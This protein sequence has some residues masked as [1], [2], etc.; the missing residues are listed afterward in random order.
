MSAMN[1]RRQ[2]IKEAGHKGDRNAS[3]KELLKLKVKPAV[4]RVTVNGRDT[5]VLTCGDGV[6]TYSF[7]PDGSLREYNS[8]R[9]M[10]AH[11]VSE[12]CRREGSFSYSIHIVDPAT[13]AAVGDEIKL[14]M[15]ETEQ[16]RTFCIRY[17]PSSRSF[18]SDTTQPGNGESV[19]C[20]DDDME[21]K[22]LTDENRNDYQPYRRRSF[23]F[24][25][26][27]KELKTRIAPSPTQPGMQQF[28][29]KED[30]DAPS[31]GSPDDKEA[32]KKKKRRKALSWAAVGAGVGGLLLMPP[33]QRLILKMIT[34]GG[35][36]HR[37]LSEEDKEAIKEDVRRRT[38]G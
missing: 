11:E 8:N 29:E 5:D 16:P 25:K 22:M 36:G 14:A 6:L 18:Y 37:P 30:G 15:K 19:D 10:L 23:N 2:A 3:I 33:T 34:N 38:I 9:Q 20:G 24:Q 4:Y 35:R 13:N 32:K 26:G 28:S 12:I 31:P 1:D 7:P 17:D 21:T 27:L